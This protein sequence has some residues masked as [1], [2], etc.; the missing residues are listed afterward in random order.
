MGYR[1]R[2][3]SHFFPIKHKFRIFSYHEPEQLLALSTIKVIEENCSET[4]LKLL[5]K[6]SGLIS[7]CRRV[8]MHNSPRA[9]KQ[10][11]QNK[12]E[13]NKNKNQWKRNKQHSPALT[14]E[15]LFMQISELTAISVPPID[16]K[17]LVDHSKRPKERVPQIDI[18]HNN[19]NS[20]Q[21]NWMN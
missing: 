4:A 12:R 15:S 3:I 17:M 9:F 16:T 18:I 11:R 6:H 10:K 5:W 21:F 7:A 8:A 20:K 1:I 19:N 13:K 2:W 14:D